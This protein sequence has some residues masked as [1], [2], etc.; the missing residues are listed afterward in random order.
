M[1]K[2]VSALLNILP[3]VLKPNRAKLG[4]SQWGYKGTRIRCIWIL[5]FKAIH[6]FIF[7]HI[8]NLGDQVSCVA[9]ND[10]SNLVASGGWDGRSLSSI[11]S[12]LIFSFQPIAIWSS[13]WVNVKAAMK[14]FISRVI[15]WD[16]ESA[17]LL[18]EVKVP[19]FWV[20]SKTDFHLNS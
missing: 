16:L 13:F 19:L 5:N 2:M 17:T 9:I 14:R 11:F 12:L 8:N 6:I 18:G 7:F 3:S 10:K 20:W 15:V 1:L 4:R